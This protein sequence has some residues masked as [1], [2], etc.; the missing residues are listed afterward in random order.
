MHVFS[1]NSFVFIAHLGPSS[2]C[3]SSSSSPKSSSSLN[4]F[5]S[6]VGTPWRNTRQSHSPSSFIFCMISTKS[7]PGG[8]VR[9]SKVNTSSSVGMP[10]LINP[11]ELTHTRCFGLALSCSTRHDRSF[12]GHFFG[13]LAIT[14]LTLGHPFWSSLVGSVRTAT[15]APCVTAIVQ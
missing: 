4:F 8:N 5:A 3:F 14:I 1:T 7:P 6:S 15:A 2:I 11:S 13:P 10:H 9:S 12:S